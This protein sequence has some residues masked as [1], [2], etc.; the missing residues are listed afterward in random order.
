M[1]HVAGNS[2]PA[3]CSRSSNATSEHPRV[4]LRRSTR[5]WRPQ[6]ST[7]FRA[8]SSEPAGACFS[9]SPGRGSRSRSARRRAGAHGPAGEQAEL[10]LAHLYEGDS[11]WRSRSW[12]R[13]GRTGFGCAGVEPAR[14]P[15]GRPH[16]SVRRRVHALVA[17]RLTIITPSFNQGAFIERTIRSVLDQGYD[18]PRVPDRRWRLHGR[19]RGGDPAV[20]GPACLVG[21]RA[22]CGPDRRD[23]QGAVARD[24]RRRRLHQQRRLLPAGSVRGRRRRPRGADRRAGWWCFPLRGRGREVRGVG[25]GATQTGPSVVDTRPVGRP[26]AIELLAPRRVPRARPV[27]RGHALRLRTEHGLRLAFARSCPASSSRSWRCV[28]STTRRNRRD[29]EP[30]GRGAAALVGLYRPPLTPARARLPR[31]GPRADRDRL[32]PRRHRAV[33]PTQTGLMA[34]T[35]RTDRAELLGVVAVDAAQRSCRRWPKLASCTSSKPASREDREGVEVVEVPVLPRV[36][37]VVDH[38]P[39][40]RGAVAVRAVDRE[41]LRIGRPSIDRPEPREV[42]RADP[43]AGHPAAEPGR[44]RPGRCGPGR[45]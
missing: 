38:V 44:L 30:V 17:P 19:V 43:D 6:G 41:H 9:R 7:R 5:E 22:G 23:Q 45:A 1:N 11:P 13:L 8:T 10:A 24:R 31:D 15:R 26:S 27:P 37:V 40:R 28:S 36:E 21:L 14:R 16:A 35:Q 39:V 4:G 18:E 25:T 42:R 32:L 33:A 20:R 3:R 34:S 2:T 29:Q 12:A